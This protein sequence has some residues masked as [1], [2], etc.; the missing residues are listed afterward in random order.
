[1]YTLEE[2]DHE[3]EISVLSR[4]LDEDAKEADDEDE[5]IESKAGKDDGDE[6]GLKT[7][8]MG[9]LGEAEATMMVALDLFEGSED[10]ASE[11]LLGEG[12]R[13]AGRGD[14]ERRKKRR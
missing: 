13:M 1:M 9:D 6:G 10:N 14:G 5:S 12:G 11:G 7:T 4:H 2:K 3:A 8:D